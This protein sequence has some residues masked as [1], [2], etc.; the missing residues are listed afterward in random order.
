M[1][2]I[3]TFEALQA[4]YNDG[5]YSNIAINE[6]IE[7]HKGCSTGFVR[8]F[9]KGVI[10]DTIL[11]DYIIGCLAN[12]GL[13]GIKKDTLI[14]LRMGIYA[15]NSLNS[16][17]DYAA[18]NEAVKLTRKKTRGQDKFV[19][20]ILRN[21]LRQRDD[22]EIPQD[23]SVKY[24]FNRPIVELIKSQYGK[25]TEDILRAL[26]TPSAF[27]IRTNT[28]KLSRAELIDVLTDEGIEAKAVEGTKTAIICDGGNVIATEAFN[29]GLF[30]VQ[31]LSSIIAI[32]EFTPAKGS[33][34]LDMCAAPGGKT[35]AM[36]EL[37]NN[38]GE[39]VA[40]DV[41]E[42]RLELI[43]KTANRLGIDIIETRMLDG[44]VHDASLDGRFGYVLADV[45]CS[46]LGVIPSKPE[47][48]LK[49]YDNFDELTEIQ[50]S[51]LKNAVS[52]CEPGGLIEYSTC[53]IN[54][55]E[56]EGIIDKALKEF[57]CLEIVEKQAI[58]PYN[59]RIGFFYCILRK[60]A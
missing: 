58:M 23:W 57:T 16:V 45:P 42:H 41:Y 39:I 52:Y 7:R 53:T 5:A 49:D 43:N 44:T 1:D 20:A 14:I 17:P 56:N 37:M 13:S 35:T 12:K 30:T 28:T 33:K 24:S 40:C 60:N 36:A 50:L 19:N 15:I 46:G 11:N 6:A 10:R 2:W 51:I 54:K 18:V 38:E 3:A 55:N 47:I 29:N 59:N 34:V 9:T 31:S 48:K 22:I 8:T 32:E 4:V 27:V 25:D 21:Y 26:N